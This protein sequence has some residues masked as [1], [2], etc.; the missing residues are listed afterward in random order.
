VKER[1]NLWQHIKAQLNCWILFHLIEEESRVLNNT[2]H[3]NPVKNCK[4][5][6]NCKEVWQRVVN[7]E[8]LFISEF[9]HVL[10]ELFLYET[11]RFHSIF[12]FLYLFV[13]SFLLDFSVSANKSIEGVFDWQVS[14]IN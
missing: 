13:L 12:F 9:V 1:F 11:P 6:I 8:D 5:L 2:F 14:F 7:L 4:A 10:I 3:Y